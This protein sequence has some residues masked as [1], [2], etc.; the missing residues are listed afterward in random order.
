M[1]GSV[2]G[3]FAYGALQGREVYGKDVLEVGSLDVNGTVRPMVE[4]TRRPATYIGVD[5]VGG[6]GVDRVLDAVDLY[7]TFGRDA[8]DVVISTEMM[9][10]A[11]DWKSSLLNMVAV[12]RPGGVLVITTRGPGFPYHHPPD[13]WRYTQKT[14]A[15][16]AREL[17]LESVVLM[18]DPEMH[19]VFVKLRKPEN[20]QPPMYDNPLADIEAQRIKEPM[21]VLGLPFQPDGC[22]Y[23]RFWQPFHQLQKHWGQTVVIPPPGHEQWR[24]EDDEIESF[25]VVSRQRPGGS[26]GVQEWE[27]WARKTKLV[28][29]TD[30]DLLNVDP[31]GLPH[32]LD[33][34]RLE[35]IRR[36]LRVSDLVTV[37]TEPLI[38]AFQRYNDNIVVIPDFIHARMLDMERPQRDKVTINW[39][40]GQSHLQDMVMIQEPLR[41]V[42]QCNDVD[43]HFLGID[44]SPLVGKK[45]RFTQFQRNV[46]DYYEKLD[47]DIGLA[48]LED[49]P[50]NQ[51][52][53]NIKVLEYSAL[54]IPSIASDITPYR[55]FIV[56]GETG[57]LVSSPEE[58]QKR[59]T[60]LINDEAM[61]T[62]MGAKA[63]EKAA[64][65]TIQEGWKHW[66]RAYEEVAGYGRDG[67]C[68]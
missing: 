41:N 46:W 34:D 8:F 48:P 51:C 15:E 59:M 40:G 14:F 21:K 68:Q 37:S 16:A 12:L 38:E 1:H 67:N 22:G 5:V 60:E 26:I 3:F 64:G 25:D 17:N 6:P 58:W 36:C 44:Y 43:M 35:T 28:Y 24:P 45:C 29:E 62:E 32:L 65:W 10:H 50:F 39:A 52:R 19:G 4:G 33:E 61:R 53:A 13:R 18:D 42:L 9:E 63:K 56:D 11:E 49:T 57:Y 55:D 31:S 23:Y 2:L 30:D 20:W 54:G 27:R 47:G 66:A 7:E